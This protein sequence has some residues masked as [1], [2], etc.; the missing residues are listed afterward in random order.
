M[1]GP[2]QTGAHRHQKTGVL[3]IRTQE[4]VARD[5]HI[6]RGVDEEVGD[7]PEVVAEVVEEEEEE[8]QML[9]PQVLW[10]TQYPTSQNNWSKYSVSGI[11][12][13]CF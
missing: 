10:V 12:E 4:E 11:P 2:R 6:D 5:I 7:G 1:T 3:G 13:S 9:T 8:H